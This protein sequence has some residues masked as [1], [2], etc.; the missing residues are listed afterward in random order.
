[1][2][3][4]KGVQCCG[5]CRFIVSSKVEDA[6]K[7]CVNCK[8][9]FCAD[10]ISG[11]IKR[12]PFRL[13]SIKCLETFLDSEIICQTKSLSLCTPLDICEYNKRRKMSWHHYTPMCRDGVCGDIII[14]CIHCNTD[15]HAYLFP[16]DW[17]V[18]C[19]LRSSLDGHPLKYHTVFCSRVCELSYL[20]LHHSD[21]R[22]EECDGPTY[23][24][25]V[26]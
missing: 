1:M 26:C 8:S 9:P 4:L 11:V 16:A 10:C 14:T 23:I 18:C 20:Q 6:L 21:R 5:I 13:C 15:A 22:G 17:V 7:L 12:R 3:D 2:D 24:D 25:T 19:D